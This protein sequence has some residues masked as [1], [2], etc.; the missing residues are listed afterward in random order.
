VWVGT[1]APRRTGLA[2]DGSAWNTD[3]A[4]GRGEYGFARRAW[5]TTAAGHVRRARAVGLSF[6]ERLAAAV[7]TTHAKLA[8]CPFLAANLAEMRVSW[9]STPTSCRSRR[10][11]A[12]DLASSDGR[13]PGWLMKPANFDPSGKPPDGA[14]DPRHGEYNVSFNWRPEF[15]R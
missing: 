2:P 13:G 3:G 10:H 14:V 8:C 1:A 9:T 5:H 6:G 7:L 15:R 12:E 11:D 4:G